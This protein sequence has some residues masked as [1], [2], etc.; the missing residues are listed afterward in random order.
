MFQTVM[1]GLCG[2]NCLESKWLVARGEWE[3][4]WEVGSGKWGGGL[5]YHV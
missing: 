4:E 1:K 2:K 5:G 3:W